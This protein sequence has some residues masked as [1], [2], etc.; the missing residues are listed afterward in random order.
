MN[1]T[2]ATASP[3]AVM[4]EGRR[5]DSARR[6][7]RVLKALNAA[8]ASGEE[9]S[10][11]SIARQAGVDRTFLYRHRDLLEQIHALEAQ[12][13]NT[14]SIGPVVSR[15]SLLAD[16]LAAQPR[17]SSLAAR[18]QQLEHRLSEQLGQQAWNESGLGAPADID[19]LNQKITHLE[20][21]V[22][23]LRLQL[24]ERDQD[25]DAAR[26]AN[27]ELITR[28]NAPGSTAPTRR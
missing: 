1:S 9:I 15:A 10:V 28:I 6:R 19:A 26:A 23:D 27:R 22:T 8:A 17:A 2:Q 20:Q 12:P 16:L 14:P 3:A 21:H 24:E 5:A 4:A 7:Q 11:T 25:L 13:P 18:I